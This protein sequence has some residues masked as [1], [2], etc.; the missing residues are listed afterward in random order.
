VK[1]MVINEIKFPIYGMMIILSILIGMIYIF[2]N[3]K[4]DIKK[5]RR[6]S[7]FFILVIPFTIIF[8][9]YFTMVTSGNFSLSNIGLS[10]YGGLIGLLLSALIFEKILP[11]K[12]KI[13]KY[14][15]LALPL[16]YG[17]SKLG[18]TFVGCCYGIP[19]NGPL[20]ISYPFR[21]VY[22][23]FPIQ[24]TEV[25][26]FIIAFFILN[27]F[28]DKKNIIPITVITGATLKFLL[29]FLRHSHIDQILSVNQIFSILLVLIAIIFIV[30]ENKKTKRNK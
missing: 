20:N 23:V 25:L 7:L 29:D 24:L 16:I 1:N 18:C 9:I 22:N 17:I 3:I 21:N 5:D 13:F 11:T 2:F 27:R 30:K 12:W 10:S 26:V 28:K 8:G 4:S 19:Y 6:L 15:I 14:T